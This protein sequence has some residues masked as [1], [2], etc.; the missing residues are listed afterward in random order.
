ML[1][2]RPRLRVTT[3]SALAQALI[4]SVI[5]FAVISADLWMKSTRVPPPGG[6][7]PITYRI[8]DAGLYADYKEHPTHRIDSLQVNRGDRLDVKKVE[9][10]KA[11][12]RNRRPPSLAFSIGL[13]VMI[14][15][16]LLAY[17]SL[18]AHL[19][20]RG[21][22]LRIHVVSLAAVLLVV[23][24]GKALLIFSFLPAFWIPLAGFAWALGRVLDRASG[25]LLGITCAFL[26]G[27]ANASDM[28]LT[29]VLTTQVLTVCLLSGSEKDRAPI[30]VGCMASIATGLLSYVGCRLLGMGLLP[31]SD[32]TEIFSSNLA[33]I[34]CSAVLSGLLVVALQ[35][36]LRWNL[37]EVSRSRLLALADFGAPLLK[38]LASTAP[39]TWQH[40][41]AMAN[42]AE[43]VAN[44]LGCNAILARVGALYH[45][46]GK[47]LQP[48][49]FAENLRGASSPH[50]SMGPIVSAD[51]IVA[52]VVQGYKMARQANLPHQVVDFIHMHH[53]N[54]V[55]E[56]FWDKNMKAG[57][58]AGLK[59]DDFRYPGLPPQTRETG[60]LAVVDSVEAASKSLKSPDAKQIEEL[61]RRIVFGKL[62]S[63]QLDDSGLSVAELSLMADALIEILQSQFHIRPQYPWQEE[64]APSE[65]KAVEEKVEAGESEDNKKS[66]VP[67]T[68]PRAESE[69]EEEGLEGS[70]EILEPKPKAPELHPKPPVQSENRTS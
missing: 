56:Y 40:T 18:Q 6:K 68:A 61:V 38:K 39:G 31:P 64:K 8:P 46:I 23:A 45:D 11:M 60:I 13:F 2:I 35:P 53:G 30:Y 37:G 33:A 1:P 20:V 21:R 3:L 26:L 70:E 41:L 51:A 34:T 22:H 17:S 48:N 42:M 67:L 25:I 69:K 57:N 9:M 44:R 5:L 28:A 52:H 47:S 27:L 49:Y 65:K 19:G 32:T 43:E 16:S 50:D 29:V 59:E 15:L 55:L 66:V 36:I 4:F 12:E 7:S 63:G 58:P 24:G 14:F 54:S 10:L 62:R